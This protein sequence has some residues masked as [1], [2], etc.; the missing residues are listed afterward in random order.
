M[1]FPSRLCH[2]YNWPKPSKASIFLSRSLIMTE[3][4]KRKRATGRLSH[5]P[6][7]EGSGWLQKW[8]FSQTSG[9]SWLSLY[10]GSHWKD[11]VEPMDRS[12]FDRAPLTGI[13][14][15]MQEYVS[16]VTTVGMAE[17]RTSWTGFEQPKKCSDAEQR[18][19]NYI[20]EICTGLCLAYKCTLTAFRTRLWVDTTDQT[21]NFWTFTVCWLIIK[22]MQKKRSYKD[23]LKPQNR[24]STR[25]GISN[26]PA[27]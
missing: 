3:L 2:W 8:F 19:E 14:G 11:T 24:H 5:T 25:N 16:N 18:C 4:R 21:T 13:P 27:E 7:Q 17:D 12:L 22:N 1:P 6:S 23:I 9:S 10:P 15:S 26:L 20:Q